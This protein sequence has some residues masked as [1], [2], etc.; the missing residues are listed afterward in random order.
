LKTSFFFM[1]D[2]YFI[3][4]LQ[5]EK[6]GVWYSGLSSDPK[7]RLIQHNQGKSKFTSGHIPWKIL[8]PEKAGDLK[9]A[10]KMEK[11]YKSAAGKRK[12][13]KYWEETNPIKAKDLKF[14]EH[15]VRGGSLPVCK[16]RRACPA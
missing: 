5:S 13:K 2:E 11:Y 7:S 16:V 10:R 4:L 1:N 9:N 14:N 12:L 8:Y 6:S 3:Y 15:Y